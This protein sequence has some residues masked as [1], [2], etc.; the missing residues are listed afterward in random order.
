MKE[1]TQQLEQ[2][3]QSDYANTAGVV[4]RK[5]GEVVYEGYFGEGAKDAPVQVF[6]VTKSVVS[7]LIGIA[8]DK[9][10]I[11]S[12][13]Q[14]V[15]EFF[16]DYTVKRGEKTIQNVTLENMLTMTS[17]YK[18]KSAP[19]TKYFSSESWVKS[20]LDLLGG[21]GQIGEFRY[22]PLIG[23]DILTGILA[24]V[25][26]CSALDFAKQ[27][28]FEPMGISVGNN[29]VFKSKEEQ[30]SFTKSKRVNGWV[31]DPM[32]NNTAGWGL[33]LTTRD[34][35]K[36]GQLYLD[37]GKWG[38]AQIVPRKWI[39]A[40]TTEHSRCAQWGNLAYGYLWWLIDDKEKSFAAMGD[41]GNIIYVNRQKNLVVSSSAYF[42]PR[43]KDRIM[44][45]K[46]E[47]EP[48]FSEL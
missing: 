24:N 22:A 44:L 43:A 38:E 10:C 13:Q 6:S 2:I 36:I 37:G 48:L 18:Y 11:K 3:I 28:L 8:M 40:S 31:A 12:V 20:S 9:G 41:G 29:I 47:I 19:Y 45:I 4:V 33:C 35:A 32:G 15:L 34:M 21:R 42:V 7:A 27:N 1:K 14:K 17:P 39:D 26:G 46:K 30:L 5:N 25:T 23:P 16:D